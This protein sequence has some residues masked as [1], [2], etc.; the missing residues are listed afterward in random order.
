MV[1]VSEQ[2]K[3][4]FRNNTGKKTL[5]VNFPDLDL[6]I[7]DENIIRDSLSLHE[8]ILESDSIEFVGCISSVLELQF[9]GVQQRIKGERI[10]VSIQ[11][12]DTDVIPLFNG[13]V[14]SAKLEGYKKYKKITAYDELYKKG[15]IDVAAWY[16]SLEFPIT[17]K[18]LR[19]SLFNY[20]GL[21]RIRYENIPFRLTIPKAPLI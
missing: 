20:I 4:A 18:N 3:L 21:A 13:V 15:A 7:A 19:D 1:E 16:N 12:G 6:T 17:L 10:E 14:D 2:T 9:H 8:S 5:K 11:C